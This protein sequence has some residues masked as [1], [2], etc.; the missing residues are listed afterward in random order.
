M[1]QMHIIDITPRRNAALGLF[2]RALEGQLGIKL[3]V[4][5]F[6]ASAP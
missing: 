4:T 2:G 6:L 3:R 1:G 5:E